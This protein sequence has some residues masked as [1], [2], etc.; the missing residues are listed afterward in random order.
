MKFII[1]G[2]GFLGSNLFSYLSKKHKVLIIN[3]S[4]PSFEVVNNSFKV[5]N[6]FNKKNLNQLINREDIII[7]TANPPDSKKILTKIEIYK[8]C[9]QL[10]DLVEI[11]IDKRVSQFIYFSSIKLYKKNKYIDEYSETKISNQYSEIKFYCE[12]YI[13]KRSQDSKINFK[14]VRISNVFGL[15]K[16]YNKNFDKLLIPSIIKSSFYNGTIVLDRPYFEKDF[17]TIN[18]FNIFID[19]IIKDKI[20]NNLKIYNLASFKSKKII[21]I[22]KK[23][24]QLINKH[25]NLKISI[26]KNTKLKNKINILSRTFDSKVNFSELDFDKNLLRLIKFYKK[27]INE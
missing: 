20:N 10:K 6:N 22:A 11:A 25:Y 16:N 18:K 15:T 4:H 14:I 2:F 26:I 3:K 24:K 19:K 5:V 23:I 21:D 9:K 17:I 7:F 8:F 13:K 27:K 1:I 12:E